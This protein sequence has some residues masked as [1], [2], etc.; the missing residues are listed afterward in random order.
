M[1]ATPGAYGDEAGAAEPLDRMDTARSAWDNFPLV[2]LQRGEQTWR[3][4]R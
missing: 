1:S 2:V 4:L 3:P